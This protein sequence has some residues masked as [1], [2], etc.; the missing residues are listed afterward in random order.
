[1]GVAVVMVEKRP[2]GAEKEPRRGDLSP[3]R[4]GRGRAAASIF[5]V[6]CSSISHIKG[7]IRPFMKLKTYLDYL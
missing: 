7:L 3:D 5:I 2:S 4:G 1:M 6:E